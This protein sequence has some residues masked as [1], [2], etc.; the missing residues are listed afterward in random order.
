MKR[1]SYLR[2]FF[3]ALAGLALVA[4]CS[5]TQTTS[6]PTPPMSVT[7]T[8]VQTSVVEPATVSKRDF[9][10]GDA[11]T[12]VPYYA[13][14][15]RMDLCG[16]AVP[17]DVADAWERFDKEFTLVVYNHA[18]VYLWLKRMERYFPWIEERLH[19]YGLPEDLKYVAIVESDLQ[20]NVC[21]PKGAAGPW[22][23]MP[24]TGASYGL[25]QQ[26]SCDKRFDFEQST[27]AAFRLLRDLYSR[28]NNWA[29]AIATYNCGDKRITDEMRSQGVNN[30][31]LLKLPLETERYVFRILAIKAVLSD[32]A[33][34]GY[35]LPQ[36]AGYQ[37]LKLDRVTVNLSK[38]VP[39]QTVASA[40]GI[41]Y[42]EFKK[43]N[44]SFRS[45]TIPA[46][47]QELKLPAGTGAAFERNFQSVQI[48][49][50][51][52]MEETTASPVA[53][54][55]VG[56][57]VQAKAD[58]PK[59][60]AGSNPKRSHTVKSGETLS[61][62]ARKYEVSIDDLKKANGIKGDTLPL[63]QTIIIP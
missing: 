60:S 49:P 32:P 17:L 52:R 28:Y 41:T 15:E 6:T 19:S 25:E 43:I 2:V 21:S 47:V 16:E 55:E 61:G 58:P 48:P 22:Q 13:P 39:I 54:R 42:R 33:R 35:N 24:T 31:Y 8:S 51:A 63:G 11:P 4:G 34:Y 9:R 18:Q 45:D 7:Q 27:D 30:Y 10:H 59:P 56:Q 20:P 44:P 53:K 46:G 3:S 37:E 62:L 36:G 5:T 29:L 57:A 40:A 38:P 12:L 26:G 14:P 50:N 1:E 23:F